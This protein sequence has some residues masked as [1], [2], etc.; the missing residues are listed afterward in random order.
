MCC[1][2]SLW[3][4]KRSAD[5]DFWGIQLGTP[6]MKRAEKRSLKSYKAHFQC[7]KFILIKKK[8]KKNHCLQVEIF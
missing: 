2:E 7:C 5:V 6:R 4:R 3:L 8:R 1:H